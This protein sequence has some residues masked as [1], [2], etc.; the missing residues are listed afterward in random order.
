MIQVGFHGQAIFAAHGYA[1]VEGQHIGIVHTAGSIVHQ[2]CANDVFARVMCALQRVY[3]G[4][5]GGI[6]CF[7]AAVYDVRGRR[8]DGIAVADDCT[9]N[10]FCTLGFYQWQQLFGLVDGEGRQ[11]QHGFPLH[12]AGGA[13][14]HDGLDRRIA[15]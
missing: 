14:I 7:F 5:D 12:D 11:A 4:L 13:G 10:Q 1:C 6:S 8:A 2:G 15:W 3:D 9:D